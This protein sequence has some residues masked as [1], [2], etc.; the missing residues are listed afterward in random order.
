MILSACP[1]RCLLCGAICSDHSSAAHHLRALHQVL[2]GEETVVGE[3]L[4]SLEFDAVFTA[5]VRPPASVT[6]IGL[7]G[8][9]HHR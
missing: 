8:P 1:S 4:T 9:R 5:P 3:P 2:P 6:W 7:A